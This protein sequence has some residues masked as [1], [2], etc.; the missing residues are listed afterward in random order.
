MKNLKINHL[1]NQLYWSDKWLP[2]LLS[3]LISL[4]ICVMLSEVPL[5]YIDSIF[6]I[7]KARVLPNQIILST[8]VENS[9]KK[10]YKYSVKFVSFFPLSPNSYSVQKISRVLGHL[11]NGMVLRP[12]YLD[13]DHFLYLKNFARWLEYNTRLVF[14]LNN[15][16]FV[17]ILKD[18]SS[19][20]KSTFWRHNSLT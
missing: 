12:P 17:F 11:S 19:A 1:F 3:T 6:L 4:K 15:K 10:L 7:A 16:D 14:I 18:W 8:K 20:F 9:L 5:A 2:L 13:S